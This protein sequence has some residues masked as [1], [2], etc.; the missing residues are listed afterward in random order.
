MKGF[1]TNWLNARRAKNAANVEQNR[2]ALAAGPTKPKRKTPRQ[3]RHAESQLQ[4]QCVTWFRI[5]HKQAIIFAVPN[6]MHLAGGAK[7]RAIQMQRFKREGLLP[8]VSDL[9]IVHAG[10]V[11]FVELKDDDGT[12]SKEQM[13]FE[14]AVGA[15]NQ[16]YFVVRS[17]D[18]FRGIV[19]QIKL[20]G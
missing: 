10:G 3:S 17:F 14:S 20:F 9:V 4:Q 16:G 6:G 1:D 7:Q 8:G 5:A 13:A 18:E 11:A 12:Q 2:A 15:L 19:D